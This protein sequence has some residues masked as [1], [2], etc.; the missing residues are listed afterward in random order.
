MKKFNFLK[1]AHWVLKLNLIFVF[2]FLNIWDYATSREILNAMI[3]GLAM[4]SIPMFLWYTGNFK[5][6]MLNT[7]FS[8]LEFMI[9]LIFIVQSFELGGAL[10]GASKSLFWFPYLTLAGLNALMGLRIYAKRK[11][12]AN[13]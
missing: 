5:A 4:F 2:I 11:V 1:K 8:I 6:I 10:T 3:L 13:K 12:K 7:L 9:L